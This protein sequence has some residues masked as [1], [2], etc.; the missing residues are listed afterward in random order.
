LPLVVADATLPAEMVREFLPRLSVA[1][2]HAVDTPHQRVTQVM[3][4][5]MGVGK[6]SLQP[7]PPGKRKPGKEAEVANKRQ[8]LIAV[9]R[10]LFDGRRGL[11][12]TYQAIED[13]FRSAGLDVAHFGAIEGLDR[14]KD[15][16]VLVIIGRTLPRPE[17]IRDMAAAISGKPVPLDNP[18]EKIRFVSLRDGRTQPLQCLR[19]PTLE[20]EMIRAAVTE[21]GLLQAIGRAR[22]VNRGAG[23]EVEVFLIVND[24]VVP[25][26]EVEA[27]A[28]FQDMEPNAIDEMWLRRLVMGWPS[29]AAKVWPDLF[30]NREAA[31]K[32]Y[33]RASKRNGLFA[34]AS[35]VGTFPTNNILIRRCPH[36]TRICVRFQPA[37]PKEIPRYCIA[38]PVRFP[39]LRG[40]LEQALGPLAEF[41]VVEEEAPANDPAAE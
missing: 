28:L 11:V 16:D 14:W 9:C 22:G 24:T 26:L 23:S 7:L 38:D 20:A 10:H 30:K 6:S 39:D 18:D 32:A 35:Y 3:T 13:E 40:V 25:G 8:R 21:A 12:I 27:V 17:N 19:Y 4:G 41:E 1:G 2:G 37:G 5:K 34:S 33:Q 15:V 36:V 31:K 29:D